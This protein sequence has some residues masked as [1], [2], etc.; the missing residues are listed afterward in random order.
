MNPIFPFY[1]SDLQVKF[2]SD[3]AMFD[4][5]APAEM[6]ERMFKQL[7]GAAARPEG[8]ELDSSELRLEE[9]ASLL[10]RPGADREARSEA[11]RCV[12]VLRSQVG[13]N[14]IFIF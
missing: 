14:T 9:L 1:K 4:S 5:F 3:S 6:E 2:M 13:A 12:E 8:D 10:L 7:L 11:P